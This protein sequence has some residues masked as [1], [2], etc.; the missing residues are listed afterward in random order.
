MKTEFKIGK[1]RKIAGYSISILVSAII[2]M[3]AVSKLIGT[4]DMVKTM[5]SLPNF[6]NMMYFIGALELILLTLYWVPKTSNLGFFLLCSFG[7]A[8]ILAE[9]VMGKVP[10]GGIMVSTFF[11]VGTMLRKPSLSGLGI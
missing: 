3:A 10:M 11:Y 4:E 5:N 7:G 2:F 8:C 1:T 9:M 6:G